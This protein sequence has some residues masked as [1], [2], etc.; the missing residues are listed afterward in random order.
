MLDASS[1]VI[2][3]IA[4]KVKLCDLNILFVRLSIMYS[5]VTCW[6]CAEVQCIEL[7]WVEPLIRI[8]N[9]WTRHQQCRYLSTGRLVLFIHPSRAIE[10]WMVGSIDIGMSGQ[11]FCSSSG[12]RVSYIGEDESYVIRITTSWFYEAKRIQNRFQSKASSI[13]RFSRL[14]YLIDR[15]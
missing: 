11:C 1:F 14:S 15:R 7:E 9:L 5:N 6:I 12:A 3:S 2:V 4:R 13:I 8:R 10:K